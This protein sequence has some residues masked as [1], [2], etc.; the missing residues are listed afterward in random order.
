MNH[1]DDLVSAIITTYNREPDIVLR[2]INSVLKQTYGNIELIVVDDSSPSYSQRREVENA[3]MSM[4]DGIIYISNEFSQG[5]CA[6]R[7]IGLSYAKGYY[8]GFLDD[9]DEWLPTKIEEQIK[10]FCDDNVAMVYSRILVNDEVNKREYIDDYQFERGYIFEKL[11]RLNFIGS[12]SSPLIKKSCIEAVGG[13]DI[14]MDS[15]QD[16]DL[17][18]RVAVRYP[19]QYIDAPLLKYYIHSGDRITSDEIKRISGY[20]RINNKYADYIDENNDIWYA[21]HIILL[22][23]YLKK[24]GRK[25]AFVLW[26]YCVRRCPFMLCKNAGKLLMIVFGLDLYMRIRNR[27]N[28]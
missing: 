17:W 23:E 2:A 3:V 25:K 5:P 4:S 22:P 10:G 12:T 9:D 14:T 1:A 19:I 27:M 20:E 18:L 6:A 26:I 13:F 11:L 24:Y 21:R 16:Y 8:I 15:C 7:N 28:Q